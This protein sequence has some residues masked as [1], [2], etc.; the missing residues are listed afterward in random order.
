MSVGLVFAEI[1]G[2]VFDWQ[3]WIF[4]VSLVMMG[5]LSVFGL[6]LADSWGVEA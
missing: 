1:L 5:G 3:P 4:A 6:M 2:W